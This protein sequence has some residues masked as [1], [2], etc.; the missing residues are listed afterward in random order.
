VKS[1]YSQDELVDQNAWL[2]AKYGDHIP[3]ANRNVVRLAMTSHMRNSYTWFA[4]NFCYI[5][6]KA[7]NTKLLRP[8][9]GQAIHRVALDS[10]LRAGLPGRLVEIKARQLG[11]TTECLARGLHFILDENKRAFI[12]V[13]DEDVA[14]AQATDFNVMLN[15][16]PKWM[17]PMRRIQSLK[18]L[19]FENPD[20][21]DRVANPGLNSA[22][23]VTVPSSFRG[24]G[25][26][27]FVSIGEYAHMDETRQEAVNM[28]LIS[29]LG[30]NP[31][32]ILII[33]TTPNGPGDS[34]H[35]MVLKACEQNP[36]WIKRIE[37]YIGEPSAEDVLNG[38]FGIPD[39]VEKGRPGVMVPALCPWRYH[40]EYCIIE[41]M[42]VAC[43]DGLK[44]IE[45]I[46]VG[47][48]TTYGRVT[49]TFK[50]ENRQ[51]VRVTTEQGRSIVCTPTHPFWTPDGWIVADNTLGKDVQLVGHQFGAD[52]Q[53][54]G[55]IS[56]TNEMGRL[57]GYYMADGCLDR[58][59][60][61]S[62]ACDAQDED[63]VD[64]VKSLV[65]AFTE[66][67][68]SRG[69]AGKVPIKPIKHG[70]SAC[71][72]VRSGRLA[73][74]EFFT[75]LG[76]FDPEIQR[77]TPC[78]PNAIFRS[79]K[80]VVREFLRGLFEGDGYRNTRAT[81]VEYYAKNVEF[82][83]QVQLLLLGFG[84]RARIYSNDRTIRGKRHK[85]W[86]M[87]LRAQQSETFLA[88]IGF[89]SKRKSW[90]ADPTKSRRGERRVSARAVESEYDRVVSVEDAGF[91]N[92]YDISVA[93]VH[94]YA[95][96][97]ILVHNTVRDKAHPRGQIA[98]FSK[99]MRDEMNATLGKMNKYGGEEEIE[100]RDRYGV[101]LERLFWRRCQIDNY[102]LPSEESCLLAF[103]QEFLTT[104][105]SAFVDTGTTPFPRESMD[106]LS[107][108]IRTPAAVGLFESEGKFAH[109]Q[110]HG[111]PISVVHRDPNPWQEIRIYAPPEPGEKY[112]MG[113]DTDVAYENEESDFT[114]AQVVRFSDNKLVATYTAKVGSHELMRQLFC[115]Y[116]W[117]G[118]CYYAIETAGM[119]YDLVRRCI[120]AGM[121][122]THYYKRYDADN[123]EP[124]KFPGWETA[125]PFMRA[126]MD[127]R[128][129]EYVCHRNPQTGKAEPLC[130]IPDAKTIAEI[131]GLIRKPSGAFKSKNG[132]DD[133]CDA[134]E[135]AWCIALDPYS[136]LHRPDTEKPKQP[137]ES[138]S[139]QWF[140][141][142]GPSSRNRP[143]L[144]RI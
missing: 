124:T 84:V 103:R 18:S 51:V 118:N 131:K 134:L 92:V 70:A 66:R 1:L 115:L 61:L 85:G 56:I 111:E 29:A 57:L 128:L 35:S 112:T 50:F 107:R 25:G 21:K 24:V 5:R 71:T 4:S 116:K 30:N 16:L 26:A 99:A 114:V 97:G 34:Y 44:P 139:S 80:P 65:T 69:S 113:V 10:Q 64:D 96:N 110:M 121:G 63:V 33:D 60:E 81:S 39:C 126:M 101:S 41:G 140:A 120:D 127:Q 49:D 22:S 75:E 100:Q 78:V 86:K 135:I 109:W 53:E 105:E 17:Q 42:L 123:P 98:R 88:E 58:Y 74:K 93:D 132:H 45:T 82:L 67:F 83:R 108:M 59:G 73:F 13:D 6:D 72:V 133:H 7:G 136:G 94:Q 12:L 141:N 2:T 9:V 43:K 28:G 90:R 143:D 32:A 38:L 54:V 91:A 104:V 46:V 14:A 117:Y 20:P 76:G 55:G 95:A 3:D 23:Q 79:P 8:F 102:E 31:Y 138:W 47:D 77:R 89:V 15:G 40:E 125:K 11:W 68:P 36:K 48:E 129:L 144:S 137:Q 142:S 130:I 19:V 62:F 27:I 122:N 37:N 106:A 87:Y 52:Y 119:G